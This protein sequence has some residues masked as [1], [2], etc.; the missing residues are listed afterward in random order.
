MNLCFALGSSSKWCNLY[1]V[2]TASNFKAVCFR[3]MS[4]SCHPPPPNTAAA[5]YGETF[6]K[7]A[8]PLPTPPRAVLLK[9]RKILDLLDP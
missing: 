8:S 9:D 6:Q 2:S 5:I 3:L 1:D 7:Q 4:S